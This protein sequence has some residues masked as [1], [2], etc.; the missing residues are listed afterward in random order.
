VRT[1]YGAAEAFV[2]LQKALDTLGDYT[3]Q[4][5]IGPRE[6]AISHGGHGGRFIM[7]APF[8]NQDL[9]G[10]TISGINAEEQSDIALFVTCDSNTTPANKRLEVFMHYDALMIVRDGNVV[11]LVL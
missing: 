1:I 7:A 4:A 9:F 6:W 5:G 2:E 10:D 11:D 3:R 8:E